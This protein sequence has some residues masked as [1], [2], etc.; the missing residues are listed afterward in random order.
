MDAIFRKGFEK[1]VLELVKKI[2]IESNIT[3]GSVDS[4]GDFCYDSKNAHTCHNAANLEDSYYINDCYDVQDS[5]DI[6][7]W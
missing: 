7:G 4:T 1:K 3:T 6:T 5:M 2:G